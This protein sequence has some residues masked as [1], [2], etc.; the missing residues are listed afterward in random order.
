MKHRNEKKIDIVVGIPSFNEADT[1]GHVTEVVSAGLKQYF[2]GHRSIIV[3]V[4][5][6]SPDNTRDA[7]LNTGTAVEKKYIST[8]GGLR[9]KGLNFLNL[10]NYVKKVG[11]DI[12]IVVDAD[13]RSITKEWIESLGRPVS[14][15]YDFVTPL[16]SRHQFDGSITNHICYPVLFGMLST[17]LR[18]PIGGDFALSSRFIRYILGKEWTTGT[19]QYGI[20]IFLTLN[21]VFGNF[22]ICQT[23]LGRKTH[24]AS[25][26]K[27]G[28]MF[29]QVI[30]TL[31]DLLVKNKE[32]WITNGVTEIVKPKVF[33]EERLPEPQ[34]LDL[35]IRELKDKCYATYVE[36]RSS[37]YALLDPYSCS[38]ID[39]IFKMDFYDLDILLWTQIFYNLLFKYDTPAE[40][41]ERK[42]IIDTLKPL[43]FA[44]SLTFN[45]STWK[46]NMKYAEMEIRDQALGFAT[47]RYYLW[48]LYNCP[49][50]VK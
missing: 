35:D 7:F 11:A 50:I 26:P 13:L 32:R 17:D 10:F 45:Y 16:Y 29:E 42:K 24:K 44:R 12:V 3:N 37:I 43:Y 41:A 15:G 48:G 2:P 28:V 14:E 30:E 20:D 31:L 47:Q 33:G 18:Q 6:N 34:E 8:S 23:A 22:K 46:Y 9:G 39:D 21:A 25:A 1:I 19:K 40:E 38:R 27:I 4:D 5:N 36:H 49:A